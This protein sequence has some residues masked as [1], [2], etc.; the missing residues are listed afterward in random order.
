MKQLV[1][2]RRKPGCNTTSSQKKNGGSGGART[3]NK[4]N[5]YAGETGLPSQIASQTAVAASPE[6]AQVV[7]AWAKLPAPLKAAILAIA[8]SVSTESEVKS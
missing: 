8:G 6:L 5:V 4:S 7:A 1:T 3:R 2:V